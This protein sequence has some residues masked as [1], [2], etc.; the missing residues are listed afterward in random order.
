MVNQAKSSNSFGSFVA[1]A[2]VLGIGIWIWHDWMDSETRVL[3]V[4]MRANAWIAGE[5]QTCFSVGKGPD[6]ADREFSQDI[7]DMLVLDCDANGTNESHDL[8][9]KFTK[10]FSSNIGEKEHRTWNCQRQQSSD[11]TTLNCQLKEPN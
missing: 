1:L 6:N 4:H 2:V 3:P 9:V 5:Y 11:G 7:A 10:P 8:Q